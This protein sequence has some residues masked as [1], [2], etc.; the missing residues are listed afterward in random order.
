MPDTAVNKVKF[1]LKN[2]HYAPITAEATDGTPTFGTPVHIPGAVNLSLDAE[3]DQNVFR[4]DNID[5]YVSNSNNGYSGSLEMALIP[6]DFRVA[7]LG[8]AVGGN[9][10]VYEDANAKAKGFALMF[11]FEGDQKATR[12]VMYKCMATRPSIASE[13]TDTTIEPVTESMDLTCS[14]VY[15]A[16]VDAWVPKARCYE[17]D[18][19]YDDFFD[20]VTLPTV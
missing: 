9:G 13:T 16:A 11:Q 18:D 6:D 12:H 19:A 3:G 20:A 17:G 14:S 10:L 4:A 8:E 15:A 1:G 2:V 5:Y 7:C